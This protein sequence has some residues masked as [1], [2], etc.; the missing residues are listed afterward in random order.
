VANDPAPLQFTLSTLLWVTLIVAIAL[1]YLRSFGTEASLS[2][3][4]VVGIGLC[5]GA[6][7]GWVARRPA[8]AIYWSLLGAFAAYVFTQGVAI[9]HWTAQL[10]W[11]LPG[12]AAGGCAGVVQANRPL[13]RLLVG[14]IAG[15]V[16]FVPYFSAYYLWRGERLPDLFVAPI[17]GA[18]LGAVIQACTLVESRWPW[19][20]ARHIYAAGLMLLVIAANLAAPRFIA[21]W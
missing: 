7:N 2:G 20:H 5:V 10:G 6:A 15:F 8:D 1:A 9:S 16:A 21:S 13:R 12:A 19:P 3:F 4:V 18:L 11:A 14:G 17:A